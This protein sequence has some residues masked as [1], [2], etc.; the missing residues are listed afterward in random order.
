LGHAV[1]CVFAAISAINASGII[2]ERL[3]GPRY[4]WNFARHSWGSLLGTLTFF[5]LAIAMAFLLRKRHAL[6]AQ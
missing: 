3:W 5:C 6:R 2:S 4:S 1:W